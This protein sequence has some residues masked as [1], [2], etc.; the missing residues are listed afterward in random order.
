[1]SVDARERFAEPGS[2]YRKRLKQ[3]QVRSAALQKEEAAWA[4]ADAVAALFKAADALIP[5]CQ[6]S[7]A[8]AEALDHIFNA[9]AELLDGLDGF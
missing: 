7:A 8:A 6:T 5:E 9:I 1:M 2:D 3:L 4:L